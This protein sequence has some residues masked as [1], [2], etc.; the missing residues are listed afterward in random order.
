MLIECKDKIL[1]KPSCIGQL[2]ETIYSR[3]IGFA[4]FV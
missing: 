1:L 2:P 3:I 4:E